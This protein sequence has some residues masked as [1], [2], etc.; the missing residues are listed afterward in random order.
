MHAFFGIRTKI[1]LALFLHKVKA[2]GEFEIWTD[3]ISE[4]VIL[5]FVFSRRR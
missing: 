2:F 5:C 3:G 4:K 1:F